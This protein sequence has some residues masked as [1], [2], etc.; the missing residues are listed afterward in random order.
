M[1][2]VCQFA[3]ARV[4]DSP[5]TAAL[6][7]TIVRK[8]VVFYLA[9]LQAIEPWIGRA[10]KTND[11]D[12]SVRSST[13]L[14][15]IAKSSVPDQSIGQYII[16]DDV[17]DNVATVTTQYC[18]ENQYLPHRGGYVSY[19]VSYDYRRIYLLPHT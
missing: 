12:Y 8:E 13:S 10:H 15:L 1:A 11:L 16:L 5:Y 17:P 19:R 14:K 2:P 7:L 9:L 6:G 18:C 4:L 3:I